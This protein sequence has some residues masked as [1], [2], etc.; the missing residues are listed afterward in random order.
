M[1]DWND[2]TTVPPMAERVLVETEE[3]SM[4]FGRRVIDQA[5][6]QQGVHWID[7]QSKPIRSPIKAWRYVVA[8][9]ETQG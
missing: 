9:G 6:P 3:G 8:S 1:S 2:M 5:S 7:D 4:L